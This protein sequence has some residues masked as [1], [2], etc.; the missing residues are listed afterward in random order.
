MANLPH[1]SKEAG[2]SLYQCTEVRTDL[3]HVTVR[4]FMQKSLPQVSAIGPAIDSPKI[5][6][7][8]VGGIPSR[9]LT[10]PTKREK[11]NHRL[12]SAD[13]DGIC[14]SSSRVTITMI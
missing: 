2:P 8:M 7:E 12:K 11:E 13:W 10:Y 14:V 6:W 3:R 5:G 1:A 4:N 9:E